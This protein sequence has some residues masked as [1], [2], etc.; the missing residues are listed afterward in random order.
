MT[1]NSTKGMSRIAKKKAYDAVNFRLRYQYTIF[2][3]A[4]AANFSTPSI[5]QTKLG[6]SKGSPRLYRAGQSFQPAQASYFSFD[7]SAQNKRG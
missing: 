5:A 2:N 6:K 4:G 3:T 1:L 7:N